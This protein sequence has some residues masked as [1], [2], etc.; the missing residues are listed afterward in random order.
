MVFLITVLGVAGIETEVQQER[1]I[2]RRVV[3]KRF[4]LIADQ[5]G[6]VA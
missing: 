5:L 2:L 3:N 1:L 4:R 6:L